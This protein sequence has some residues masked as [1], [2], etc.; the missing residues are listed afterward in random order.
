MAYRMS[1]PR[2]EFHRAIS[3]IVTRIRSAARRTVPVPL[4]EYVYAC[5]VFLSH[6]EL[7]NYFV[8]VLDRIARLYSSQSTSNG[9][10]PVSLR[11]HVFLSRSNVWRPIANWMADGNEQSLLKGAAAA[12]NNHLPTFLN[13]TSP[14]P[15]LTST[16]I[17]GA[18]TY[19][20]VPNLIQVL[21]RIG[22][23]DPKG[24][25]NQVAGTD[26]WSLL[27]SIAS[28]RTALAHDASMPGVSEKDLVARLRGL[29]KFVAA[30]DRALYEHVRQT[31]KVSA[32]TAAMP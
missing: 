24:A 1:A 2:T 4:K 23:A 27:Q 18:L 10:L 5:S 9:V 22:I 26:A 8:D 6:A 14:P 7:E 16:D 32:W 15:P 12:L 13:A 20:S 11:T 29:E 3:E 28:L 17:S 30:M 19:P 25:I 31:H 21:R